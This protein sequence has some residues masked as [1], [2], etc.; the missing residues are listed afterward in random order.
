M[1]AIEQTSALLPEPVKPKRR[2]L[3]GEMFFSQADFKVGYA[4]SSV[5]TKTIM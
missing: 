4:M 5:P 3:N 1:V 2:M